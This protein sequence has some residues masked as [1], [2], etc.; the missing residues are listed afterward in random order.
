MAEIF[1]KEQISNICEVSNIMEMKEY[2]KQL[3]ERYE[4]CNNAYQQFLD[5]ARNCETLPQAMSQFNAMLYW[6]E[7]RDLIKKREK[8]LYKICALELKEL[9]NK[10]LKLTARN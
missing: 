2:Y 7:C 6:T 8:L 1:D 3:E 5:E 4:S 10:L 9:Q